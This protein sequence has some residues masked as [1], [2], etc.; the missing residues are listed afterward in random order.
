MTAR[1]SDAYGYK[2]PEN[3]FFVKKGSKIAPDVTSTFTKRKLDEVREVLINTGV[4]KD[5]VFT[6]DWSFG[7]RSTAATMVMTSQR[8]EEKPISDEIYGETYCENVLDIAM[9]LLIVAAGGWNAL[10]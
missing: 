9:I 7:S 1:G 10:K 5:G 4:I 8:S 3:A 2:G 6:C